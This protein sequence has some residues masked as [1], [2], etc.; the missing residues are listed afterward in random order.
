M[1]SWVH[2][3]SMDKRLFSGEMGIRGDEVAWARRK[4]K[5]WV[6]R[7]SGQAPAGEEEGLSESEERWDEEVGQD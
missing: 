6:V 3:N 4:K 5:E 1:T 2:V 7:L